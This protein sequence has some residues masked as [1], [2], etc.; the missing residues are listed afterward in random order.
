MEYHQVLEIVSRDAA[1]KD[2]MGWYDQYYNLD[3]TPHVE[4]IVLGMEG[5][6]IVAVA[7][8]YIPNSGSPAGNDLPWAKSIGA[9]A[10]GVTCICIIAGIL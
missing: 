2:N 6:T 1:R 5:D 3:G 8:T 10:G 9:D 4:D 7:L